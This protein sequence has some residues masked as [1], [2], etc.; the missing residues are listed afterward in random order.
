MRSI[1]YFFIFFCSCSNPSESIK[2]FITFENSAIETIT[3][4]EILHTEN[5]NLKVKIKSDKIE[6]FH[7]KEPQ[8]V[9][10][11]GIEIFFYNDS[12][13]IKSTLTADRAELDKKNKIM[14]ASKNVVLTSLDNK[15]LETSVLFWD[16]KRNKI[17]TN[18]QVFVTTDKEQIMG[19]GFI[20]N[21]DFTNYSISNITGVISFISDTE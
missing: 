3:E 1:L 15:R 7:E 4:A 14:T 16:E 12:A 18:S 20:S 5:G 10:T 21:T 19:E 13:K 8:I 2:D 11:N 17:Y 6:R 9:L